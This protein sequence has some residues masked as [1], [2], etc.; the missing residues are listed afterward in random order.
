M[1]YLIKLLPTKLK[2]LAAKWWLELTD[3]DENN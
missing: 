2:M 3:K 1:K